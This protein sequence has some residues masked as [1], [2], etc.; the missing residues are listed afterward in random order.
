MESMMN[1]QKLQNLKKLTYI[2]LSFSAL[3]FSIECQ[4]KGSSSAD[5]PDDYRSKHNKIA[6]KY[7]LKHHYLV[8]KPPLQQSNLEKDSEKFYQ[9]TAKLRQKEEDENKNVN[10]LGN[11]TNKVIGKTAE[12]LIE[13]NVKDEQTKSLLTRLK[14]KGLNFLNSFFNK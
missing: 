1:T 7:G 4:G 9:I 12:T 13:K 14:D 2:G 5:Q 6:A 11:A 8:P 10:K 3:T